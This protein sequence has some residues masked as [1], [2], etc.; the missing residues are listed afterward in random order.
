V[1]LLTDPT[2]D[3][4]G[5]YPIGERLLTKT[6][7]P[8]V[9]PGEVGPID[10]VLLSHDQHPDNLDRAGR[11][12]L[13]TVPV[14]LSTAS[15]RERL[16]EPV[17]AL[18]RWERTEV[19][20]EGGAA[21][22]V[23]GVPALHGPE[24]SEHLVGEVTGFV[25][26]GPGPPNV[27][28][29]GD[30]ASLELMRVIGERLVPCDFALLSAGA[31]QTALVGGAFLTLT[32]ELGG[33]RSDPRLAA[34]RAA[35]LRRLDA[36][37]RGSGHAQASVRAGRPQSPPAAPRARGM[38]DGSLTQR[39][40]DGAV[41]RFAGQ[42]HRRAAIALRALCCIDRPARG[43]DVHARASSREVD[44]VRPGASFVANRSS[45]SRRG[46]WGNARRSAQGPSRRPE[47]WPDAL[48]ESRRRPDSD[49]AAR[50]ARLLE[51]LASGDP[52]NVDVRTRTRAGLLWLRR[53]RSYGRSCNR[54][55]RRRGI[56]D[57]RH[58]SA[59]R[60]RDRAGDPRRPRHR[61]RGRSG[62]RAPS[63]WTR[64]SWYQHFHLLPLATQLL[65]GNADGLRLYL[66]HFY[67]R[68]GGER[69]LTASE[70]E[71]VVEVYARSGAFA[72]SIRWYQ[73]RV[74]R[75]LQA[76]PAPRPLET[77]TIALWGDQDPM[78]PLD[79][80]EG[81]AELSQLGEPRARRRRPFR[82]LRSARASGC[83]AAQ[84]RHRLKPPPRG[85]SPEA[86]RLV[87]RRHPRA[88]MTPSLQGGVSLSPVE[89]ALG[90]RLQ[91]FLHGSFQLRSVLPCHETPPDVGM[92]RGYQRC[93]RG[94][95]AC[96]T[97]RRQ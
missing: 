71:Q 10:A 51:R 53:F 83:R 55:C 47:A 4:P 82:A 17:R 64:H 90:G 63:A 7:E 76:A 22:Q 42:P 69:K 18:A 2:F 68:W 92:R 84:P 15:A 77:A 93:T 26:S 52:R 33:G 94:V 57:R 85:R 38:D 95:P 36:L 43:L 11:E 21:I 87:V 44:G 5:E 81:F 23:T 32:S 80:R 72:A 9:G 59:R 8:A 61:L 29:S 96:C 70:F 86:S 3:P 49:R 97:S 48:P 12:Y 41:R 56:R 67:N 45:C 30:N 79:H 39:W 27:Y 25:L 66:G 16:G 20:G 13:T 73:A 6:Q 35:P 58:R 50:L 14:V 62:G 46:G 89:T 40:K 54:G 1:R 60:A 37:H 74:A 75:R 31:A 34:D 19:R 88:A 28:V 24:G 91:G 65:D 78:R